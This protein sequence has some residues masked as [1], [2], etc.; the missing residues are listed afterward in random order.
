MRHLAQLILK[1]V[2]GGLI[3]G[4][5]QLLMQGALTRDSIHE[6]ARNA[7]CMP[8]A[9]LRFVVYAIS[10]AIRLILSAHPICH[11]SICLTQQLVQQISRSR[12]SLPLCGRLLLLYVLLLMLCKLLLLLYLLLLLL[13]RLLYMLLLSVP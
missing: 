5:A 13:L 10:P 12:L 8:Q 1:P 7:L 3:A 6:C 2:L 11:A 4:V 9:P